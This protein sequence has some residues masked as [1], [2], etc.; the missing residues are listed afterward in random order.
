MPLVAAL[1]GAAAISFS[2]IFFALADVGPFT[3]AVYRAAYAIPVLFVLWRRVRGDDRRGRRARWLAF[4]SGVLLGLDWV[5]WHIAID[6]IGT[7]LAT[8]LANCQV[9]VVALL[10][11]AL[12]GERPSRYVAVAVPV[13]LAGAALV[14]GLGRGDAFGDDPLAGT[15]WGA[16]AAFAYAGFILGYRRSNRVQSPT[17]GSLFDATVGAGLAT[18]LAAPFFGGITAP[19]W[20]A[21]G[22]LLSLAVVSQVGGWL[23]I[24]YAL[25]RL[26]A[27][28]TS[29][30]IL[31]QPVLTMVWGA[32]IFSERPSP[33]QLTGAAL[34]LAG[35]GV[36]AVKRGTA[37]PA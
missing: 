24:G 10:A 17:V 34:V 2:A 14:S 12:F 15:A 13:V 11:W 6:H 3:G 27:A 23:A 19:S 33:L 29:T 9:V 30:F 20:P 28:E 18:V 35:V 5:A 21:H 1:L 8:L 25:P 16:L 32:L 31:L 36:V 26:P 7:G 37:K 22:W 4:A